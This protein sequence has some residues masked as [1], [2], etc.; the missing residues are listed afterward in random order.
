M[1]SQQPVIKTSTKQLNQSVNK[2]EQLQEVEESIKKVVKILEDAKKLTQ[3][4]IDDAN[5]ISRI[6]NYIK[7]KRG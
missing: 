6:D 1:T 2:V 4:I 7:N 3:E 5:A